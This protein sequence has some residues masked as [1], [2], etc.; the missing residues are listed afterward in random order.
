MVDLKVPSIPQN[1][2]L[3]Q[4]VTKNRG[5]RERNSLFYF[6]LFTFSRW[7]IGDTSK[8]LILQG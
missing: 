6:L 7:G 1:S 8:L 3:G 2:L 5:E 4:G